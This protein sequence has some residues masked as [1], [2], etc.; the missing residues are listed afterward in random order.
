MIDFGRRCNN[1]KMIILSICLNTESE[2][3]KV[4][5]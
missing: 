3:S 4:S 5:L 1:P 2:T